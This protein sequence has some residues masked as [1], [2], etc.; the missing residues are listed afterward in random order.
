[1][2][3]STSLQRQEQL[4]EQLIQGGGE[5][6]SISVN[7][8]LYPR[9]RINYHSLPPRLHLINNSKKYP[10]T[11]VIQFLIISTLLINTFSFVHSSVNGHHTDV[12]YN[13]GIDRSGGGDGDD[14]DIDTNTANH[15]NYRE[16]VNYANCTRCSLQSESRARRLLEIKT[17]ILNKLG[18]KAAPNI[19]IRN[20]Q[21]LQ[22]PPLQNLL[23][24][25]RDN[26]GHNTIDTHGSTREMDINMMMA[27]DQPIADDDDFEDFYVSAEKSLSIARNRKYQ[28]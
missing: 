20:H 5:E 24:N 27:G 8:M 17:D 1:M 4:E 16:E 3:P 21:Q 6:V 22:L 23:R 14:E 28:Y 12:L 26:F 7:E 13:Q 11:F 2:D 10:S 18:L 9:R 25:N 19:T 15:H